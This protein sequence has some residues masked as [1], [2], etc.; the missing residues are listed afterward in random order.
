MLTVSDCQT[1]SDSETVR[2]SDSK[3]VRLPVSADLKFFTAG[4]VG[5]LPGM[6]GTGMT[7]RVFEK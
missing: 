1:V 3:T 5:W 2:L 4:P 7:Y 6:T